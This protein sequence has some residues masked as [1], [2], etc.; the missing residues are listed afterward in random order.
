MVRAK[1]LRLVDDVRRSLE[2]AILCGEMRPGDRLPVAQVAEEF[3]VSLTT[4]REALLML[5]NNGLVV[6]KPRRGA[7]VA[8]LSGQEAYELCQARALLESFAVTVGLEQVNDA[9]IEGLETLLEEMGQCVLPQDL[10]N[11]IRIDLAI[12]KAVVALADSQRIVE[13]WS[14]LSGQIGALIMRSVEQQSSQIDDIVQLHRE[15]VDALATGD[16]AAARYTVVHHYLRDRSEYGDFADVVIETTDAN[17][18][19]YDELAQSVGLG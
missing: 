8:R 1:R 2:E 6:N 12:H 10:P 11:V 19:V 3:N 16:K 17:Q 9:F 14:S 18:A 5:E 15:L 13:L 4:V 7:F